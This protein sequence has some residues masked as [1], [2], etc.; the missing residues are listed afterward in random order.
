MNEVERRRGI[1][2]LA[3]GLFGLAVGAL[4]LGVAQIGV[5]PPSDKVGTLVIA[6]IFGGIVQILAGITD[7]RY[8]EQLGGTALTMYGFFWL[9][10]CTAKLVSEST[11]FH[12]N[13]VLYVPIDLVYAAFSAV[14]VYLTAYRNATLCILHVFITACF[15]FTVLARLDLITETVPGLLHIMVGVMAFYHAVASLTQAFTGHQLVPLGPAFLRREKLAMKLRLPR[16][17]HS[18]QVVEIGP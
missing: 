2:V 4:T 10:V 15:S 18:H 11:S 17:D 14:M 13:M 9:T 7:I 12:L 16:A 8:D 1:D 6:L 3:I 5:I